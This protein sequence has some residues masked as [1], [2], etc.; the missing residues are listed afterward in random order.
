M[1]NRKKLSEEVAEM[2]ASL[3]N[4]KYFPGD[5]IPNE[6]ELA[7]E[8]GVSRTT[9]RE[10]IKLLCSK[11]ILEIYRGKGTFVCEDPGAQSDPLGF[12]FI[13]KDDF[14]DLF[15]MAL[16]VEPLFAALAAQK[17]TEEQIEQLSIEHQKFLEYAEKFTNNKEDV[18]IEVLKKYDISFHEGI[19]I[20]CNNVVIK[21]LLPVVS[22]VMDDPT[23]TFIKTLPS[24]IKYHGLIIDAIKNKNQAKALYYMRNHLKDLVEIATT[25]GL[26]QNMS[27][28]SIS[29]QN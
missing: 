28:K 3:I 5:K 10:A 8:F 15:E 20:S 12:K 14:A 4:K 1:Q 6:T 9:I 13:N 19:L 27:E 25:T 23:E 22:M 26:L 11:N 7:K 29:I 17:A 2:I 21:R 16:L 24:C 18:P